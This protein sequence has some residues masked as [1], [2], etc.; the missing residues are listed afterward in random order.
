MWTPA[1]SLADSYSSTTEASPTQTTTYTVNIDD[2]YGCTYTDTVRIVVLDVY[3]YDPYIY[4]PNSFT[5]NGD[6]VNDVFYIRSRYI[7]HMYFVIFDRWGEK[8][9]ETNDYNT[10]WDGTFRNQ[11][12]EPAVFDY[13][14][15]IDCFND[16]QFIKKGNITL[17]R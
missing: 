7:E 5:P 8:V 17:L 6:G 11:L 1:G 13:Y 15:E 14:L 2:G 9:F 4:I 16:T 10:G 12:L 3:C